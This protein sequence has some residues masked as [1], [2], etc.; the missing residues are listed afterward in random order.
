MRLQWVFVCLILM[1]WL[2]GC[3]H[4]TAVAIDPLPPEPTTAPLAARWPTVSP[5]PRATAVPPAT[6]TP[7]PTTTPTPILPTAT[8]SPTPRIQPT[9]PLTV[10]APYRDEP[11]TTTSCDGEGTFFRSQFPS[12]IAG[13]WRSYHVY[14]PPCYGQDGRVYPV[15][16]L[17]PGSIQADDQWLNLGLAWHAAGGIGDGRYPPFIAIMP[18]ANPLGNNLSGGPYSLE[19]VIVEEL[20]PFVEANYCAWRD[21]AGRSI[22]GIS[23]GGYWA[24]MVAFRH[25]QLFTA[26]AGH[27]SS[28]RLKTDPPPYNPLAAY[29]DADLSQMR[30]WLDWGETDFLRRGQQELT[31]LLTQ[32][33]IA[34]Q[35]T[36][37]PGGHDEAYWA[38]HVAD[39]LDW[40]TAVWPTDRSQYPLCG[41]LET[42]D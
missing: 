15:L 12:Q 30:I 31:T 35:T 6:P 10:T 34:H 21:P 41:R 26:V 33:G 11:P 7:Y 14:L 36:I 2:T 24:L 13:P 18:A 17:L 19:A 23:R 29:A 39:Y 22:G 27:S 38:A 9:F 25:E 4:A 16:Y 40:H 8:P 3:G 5:L 42:R 37:Y 32:A 28:L 20:L 1:M